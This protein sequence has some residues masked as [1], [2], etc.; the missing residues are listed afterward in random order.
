MSVL[1]TEYEWK[2]KYGTM[3]TIE[4]RINSQCNKE[5]VHIICHH[6]SECRLTYLVVVPRVSKSRMG[7]R[8]FSY[9]APLLWNQ[10]PGQV[11]EVDTLSRFKTSLKTFL[12]NKA[13]SQ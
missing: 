7:A 2:I 9:Q 3:N 6:K 4:T 10:L 13:Y 1:K 11:R 12:F 5:I 8:A